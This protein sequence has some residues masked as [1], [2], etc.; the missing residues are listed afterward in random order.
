MLHD[1]GQLADADGRGVAR[2]HRVV[3]CEAVELLEDG[4]L[5][6]EVFEHG[7]D[8][9]FGVARGIGEVGRRAHAIQ[10]RL[11][12][13]LRQPAF[14]DPAR[15]VSAIRVAS[16]L[17]LARVFVLQRDVHAM[18]SGL[19]GDLR[20][21]ASRAD[22]GQVCHCTEKIRV[23]ELS[24]DRLPSKPSILVIPF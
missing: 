5:H 8:D 15:E 1:L 17:Q 6:L 21:H 16:L 7:L 13:R 9:E 18:Q 22:H 19:L 11:G 4:A 10:R 2:Q 24:V 3:R 23:T 20:P 12:V 14:L